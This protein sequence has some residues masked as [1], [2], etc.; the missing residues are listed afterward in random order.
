MTGR[1]RPGLAFWFTLALIA[2]SAIA[3]GLNP[4]ISDET[5]E[6]VIG[7][8]Y[9]SFWIWLAVRIINRRERW[10]IALA[11]ATAITTTVLIY[12]Y[13]AVLAEI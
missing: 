1:N 5:I 3:V 2:V 12:Y 8:A 4:A 6:R 10:A 9:A 13:L 11:T 7:T